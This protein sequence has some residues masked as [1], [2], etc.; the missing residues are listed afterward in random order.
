MQFSANILSNNRCIG[1]PSGA[2]TSWE[3]LYTRLLTYSKIYFRIVLNYLFFFAVK[4][5]SY[6]LFD[7][8]QPSEG[9]DSRPS[10]TNGRFVGKEIQRRDS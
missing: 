6:F 8:G 10:E 2:G 9:H 7:L 4:N 3:I 5:I 1:I